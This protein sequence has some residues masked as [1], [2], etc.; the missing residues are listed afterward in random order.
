MAQMAYLLNRLLALEGHGFVS[1]TALKDEQL[2]FASVSLGLG[3]LASL[4]AMVCV[5]NFNK[6]LKPLLQ[7]NSWKQMP[8]EFEPI[9]QHRYAERIELD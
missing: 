8:H 4:T 6:G 2:L 3:T 1:N 9:H 7:R 5:I